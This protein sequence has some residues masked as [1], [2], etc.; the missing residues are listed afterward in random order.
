MQGRQTNQ[1]K[2]C[3][4][5]IPCQ[6]CHH[7]QQLQL[8]NIIKPHQTLV[9]VLLVPL[10]WQATVPRRGAPAGV[11]LQGMG[12]ELLLPGVEESS[13]SSDSTTSSRAQAQPQPFPGPGIHQPG[14][15]HTP[16]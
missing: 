9:L 14:I 15:L 3:G 12:W 2:D 5:P 11:L 4:Q 7:L 13:G 6:S 8:H 16:W 10:P 1:T